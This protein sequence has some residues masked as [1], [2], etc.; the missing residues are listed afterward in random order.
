MTTRKVEVIDLL[1]D[2]EPEL[3]ARRGAHADRRATP[4]S[5]E[6]ILLDD[7]DEE[8]AAG[9][10]GA[11]APSAP[12]RAKSKDTEP[13]WLK[14]NGVKR[15]MAEFG[16]MQE[17]IAQRQL[18]VERL[19]MVGDDAMRWRFRIRQFDDAVPGG[20]ALNRDLAELKRRHGHDHVL[21]EIGF[22]RDYP[23]SPLALRVVLPRMRWYTGHVTV[24]A[25]WGGVCP[26]RPS[27][28]A[29]LTA[30]RSRPRPP[31]PARRRAA[32]SAWRC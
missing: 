8:D 2:D 23:T 27:A 7:S 31:G 17:L 1:D 15:V 26:A 4:A 28:R 16:A 29:P 11:S 12:P 10:R 13:S 14:W 9:K 19:E 25:G 32:R 18:P 5:A 24:R 6:I 22:P 20:R 30:R 3:K 21:M